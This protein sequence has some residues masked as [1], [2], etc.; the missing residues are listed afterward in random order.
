MTSQNVAAVY[1]ARGLSRSQVD[2]EHIE[3][4]ETEVKRERGVTESVQGDNA[5]LREQLARANERIRGLEK[6]R[7]EQ[8]EHIT[9]LE[10]ARSSQESH[11][12]LLV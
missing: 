9:E 1:E 10:K 2:Q 4:V 11:I 6:V 12:S 8:A 3:A 5:M 7:G